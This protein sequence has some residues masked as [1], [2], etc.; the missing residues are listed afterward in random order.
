MKRSSTS[1]DKYL[2]SIS[3][4][5][6]TCLQDTQFQGGGHQTEGRHA[7][8]AA[9]ETT[10][11][12]TCAG[13]P[14]VSIVV[15][16]NVTTETVSCCCLINCYRQCPYI[17]SRVGKKQSPGARRTTKNQRMKPKSRSE[18]YL[19]LYWS[20]ALE[21]GS[22]RKSGESVQQRHCGPQKQEEQF[23]LSIRKQTTNR[24]AVS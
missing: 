10:V 12:V 15:V 16:V 18:I 22:K 11:L 9:Q 14:F 19:H 6:N 23:P 24:R 5:R 20:P 3:S 17:T 1:V 13:R 4:T 8:V 7:L 21:N 2:S